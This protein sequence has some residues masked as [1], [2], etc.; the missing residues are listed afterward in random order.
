MNG[1]VGLHEVCY[2]P[3]LVMSPTHNKLHGGQISK[4]YLKIKYTPLYEI[5]RNI[6]M[7]S[8]TWAPDRFFYFLDFQLPKC[9]EF[10]GRKY[11]QYPKNPSNICI[12]VSNREEQFALLA[13]VQIRH[14]L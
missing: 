6:A 14:R 4:K 1:R 11:F 10:N 5:C 9:S 7:P 13:K 12:G 8:P 2:G 3:A